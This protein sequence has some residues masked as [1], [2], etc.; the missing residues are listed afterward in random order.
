MLANATCIYNAYN[1]LYFVL[2][3]YYILFSYN[4]SFI[5]KI[6]NTETLLCLHIIVFIQVYSGFRN[7]F[8]LDVK[9]IKIQW[10][11]IISFIFKLIV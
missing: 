8:Y 6:E 1:L 4:I 3:L 11:N 9:T 10:D 5:C 7:S 2:S